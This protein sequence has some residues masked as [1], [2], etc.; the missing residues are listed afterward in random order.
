MKTYGR[1]EVLTHT[2]LTDTMASAALR[3]GK[4]PL[5]HMD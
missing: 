4:E 5:G 2:F 1:V 3:L